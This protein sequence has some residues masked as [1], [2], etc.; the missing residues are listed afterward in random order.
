MISYFI[1][2]I[3]SLG[4]SYAIYFLLLRKQKTFQFNRF[5]LL[6]SLLLC[7]VAP[8]LEF[9]MFNAVP[10]IAELPIQKITESIAASEHL[11]EVSFG[12]TEMVNTSQR[13]PLF[14][15]YSVITFFLVFRFL[16][17]IYQIYNLTRQNY[18]RLGR[19][20][21]ITHNDSEMISSF[22]NYLFINK[23]YTS[24][25]EAYFNIIK[26]ETAHSAELHTLDIIL[27]ELLICV[28]WFNPF[29]W[30][31][32]KSIIQNHEYIADDKTISSGIDIETYANT[33]INLGQKEY[34][35]PLTS[36]FNFIQIKN[37]IIMLHQSKSSVLNRTLKITSV[38][39]LFAGIF[40]FSS[41]K[42][43][44]EDSL[45]EDTL[46]V[47]IDAGHGGKDSGSFNEK[48]IVLNISNQLSLLSDDKI[49]FITIREDDNF[50]SLQERADFI[51]A[52]NADIM[53]SL[54]CNNASNSNANGL[55]V[56]YT[57]ETIN[58]K[59]SMA[60]GM[61]IYNQHLDNELVEKAKMKTANFYLLKNIDCPGVIVELGFL[62]NE[63]DRTR[64]NDFLHQQDI[65]KALYDG[66]LEFKDNK[67]LQQFLYKD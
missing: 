42:E 53:L 19:L 60:V 54:H 36:G 21:L 16:K 32:K 48:D 63:I 64:L 59:A 5:F 23:K 11:E 24:K 50:L 47:V 62:S 67:E 26:H 13:S 52:Q 10:K 29:I 38:I 37:R 8:F 41:C 56:Y 57:N 58:E 33:I 44:I 7:L 20:K 14:Y 25:N 3:I 12:D 45:I 9:K 39:F 22:F 55:E 65:V 30:L 15:I 1:F 18:E 34:R 6:A 61:A 4:C 27:V 28:F 2:T 17:N 40:A 66:L 35:V 49:K 51:N 43:D 31:Y 46:T